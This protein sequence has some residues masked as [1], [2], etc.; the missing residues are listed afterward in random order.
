MTALAEPAQVYV[1]VCTEGAGAA[2]T[3]SQT[4]VD[5]AKK[6]TTEKAPVR[7]GYIFT[8]WTLSTL[9]TFATRDAWGRS[10]DALTFT[11]YEHTTATAHY[12]L[13]T[14]DSDND[15]MPDGHE[16]YWYGGLAF[17]PDSDTDGDGLTFAEEIA[18]STNPL[19]ADV[20]YNAVK[21]GDG[22]VLDYNPDGIPLLTIRCEP[23]GEFFPT[24]REYTRAGSTNTTPVC[25]F[26]TSTFAY[27]TTNGVRVADAWG[28]AKDSFTFIMPSN[29][30][31]VV[32]VT[33]RKTIKKNLLYWYGDASISLDSDTDGDGFT[34]REEIAAASN[35][36]FADATF[37]AFR[38]V[39]HADTTPI[40]YNADSVPLLTMRSIPE[41]E[42]F[43]T[44]R[45]YMQVG[46]MVTSPTLS[47]GTST[48][49]YWMT[50]GV[51]VVDW[52]GRSVDTAKFPMPANDVDLVAV[53][54]RDET[55]RR[56][57]YWTGSPTPDLDADVD[58][59]GYTLVQE[60]MQGT[61]PYFPDAKFSAFQGVVH[62][63][64]SV[65]E[66]NL[67]VYEDVTGILVGGNYTP[68]F[69]SPLEGIEGEEFGE[70]ATPLT[71]DWN[72]DGKTDLFVGYAGGA[73][74]FLNVGSNAN[75]DLVEA[76]E[77][78]PTGL[79]DVF[80]SMTRPAIAAAVAR[81]AR[82]YQDGDA[83]VARDAR[84]Y[85]Y[86]SDQGGK[87]SKYDLATGEITETALHG[88]PAV[89]DMSDW[90]RNEKKGG[91]GLTHR[92]SFSGVVAGDATGIEITSLHAEYDSVGGQY[93]KL[94]GV[95]TADGNQVTLAGGPRGTSYI[96]LGANILPADNVPFTIEL[97]ATMNAVQNWSRMIDIGNGT[98]NNMF[99]AWT[100]STS[101]STSVFGIQGAN[102][103]MS[104]SG[105]GNLGTEYHFALV[106]EPQ[107][108][109]TWK[110][111]CYRQDA[112]TG[113][114]I[115]SFEYSTAGT[116]W[117][118]S[119]LGQTNCW[120]G[121]SQWSGD[122]DASAS[123][124]EMRVWERAL[125]EEELAANVL[126]GPDQSFKADDV[127]IESRVTLVALDLHGGIT[128][129]DGT[130]FSVDEI[131]ADG[132]TSLSFGDAD[133][134]GLMDILAG[135]AVGHVWYYKR[136]GETTFTLQ[137]KVWGGTFEGF[138]ED[139]AVNAVDWDDDGD[140]D[141]LVGTADGRLFLLRDPNG[142][143][144]ANLSLAAGVDS[145]SLKWDPLAQSRIRGYY[146]Y[147]SA[148][149]ANAWRKVNASM[150]TVPRLLDK[151]GATAKYDYAVTSVSRLYKT[152][153]SRPI[154][155]E[156]AKTDPATA[157]VGTVGFT[158]QPAAA[159]S[160]DNVSV[161]LSV[162]NALNLSAANMQ[163]KISFDPAVLVP[164]GVTKTGLTENMQIVE[165]RGPGTWIVS[166][167]GGTINPGGGLF[168][169]FNFAVADQTHL[170]DTA[171]TIEE[172]EL[173]SVGNRNVV[174][175][176]LRKADDV[177]LGG[178]SPDPNDPA[179]VVP[180]SLG[181]LDGD[182]RLGWNDVELFL[183]W[184]DSPVDQV[185]EAVRK[186]GDFN[187]DGVMD[188]RDYV[189]L[190]RFFRER[191]RWGGKMEGWND[192]HTSY[193]EVVK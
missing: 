151:P 60:L 105:L 57:M 78:L 100:Q 176:V 165:T 43:A 120:L 36:L 132:A 59:D 73:R 171:V 27:W 183:Q 140:L 190:K 4:A 85:L 67:Q 7:A 11:P 32:A 184:K 155:V 179:R 12:V 91:I 154:T 192:N 65:E 123:Y 19:F 41:G 191:E 131:L 167:A 97:W 103:N 126:A 181:D 95:V 118:P 84:P 70:H 5:T 79:V 133:H 121:H 31:E 55:K 35:P 16:L 49:A 72:G 69:A 14:L 119:K 164:T 162:E 135:D 51:R 111:K 1:T 56:Y 3:L 99:W 61:N 143:R 159:F 163:L 146:V 89:L 137:N 45:E 182:G 63:D 54:E 20:H 22:E 106:F 172:F 26:S 2:E 110:V 168:L 40:Q 138:A 6:Y 109:N 177:T 129:E 82:P 127:E 157:T 144:P 134:D 102:G 173:K 108:D 107:E 87:I 148:H 166:G 178:D 149:G 175:D 46:K 145:V 48:F 23:D 147:R 74:L 13:A 75:P 29:D 125:T 24:I 116:E 53:T 153:N 21:H 81:D 152:G 15:G 86:M 94:C 10:F 52:W 104:V 112:T 30:L 185:P 160:G 156:S 193:R 139:L 189:L 122:R 8:H 62:G 39:V 64:T 187:G 188:N 17:S 88:H 92:W 71:M 113:E 130:R 50:N 18:Y 66:M 77:T 76:T 186:A 115:A 90:A 34:L 180:G 44:T 47:I 161:D 141:A 25:S 169:S 83:S 158:W 98:G 128:A 96:D 117:R 142:G 68:F 101:S 124:N 9:Q 136:T 174:P 114:T 150:A 37:S 28:R 93:A 42:L 170:A 80:R 38:G 58:N 33:E